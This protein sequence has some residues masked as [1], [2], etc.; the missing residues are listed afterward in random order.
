MSSV[1]TFIEPSENVGRFRL[2]GRDVD[3]FLLWAIVIAN[4][5]A[6]AVCSP[7]KY[8][9][10]DN[11]FTR[12]HKQFTSS[13]SW[14]RI[15]PHFNLPERFSDAQANGSTSMAFTLSRYY[16]SILYPFELLYQRGVQEQQKEMQRQ[17]NRT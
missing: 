7:F 2:A 16:Y 9:F 17:H 5:G 12:D 3:L 6:N 10:C 15:L 11:I 4:G 14:A 13:G 8:H 1:W